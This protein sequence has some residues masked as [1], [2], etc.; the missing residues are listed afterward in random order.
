MT[1]DASTP[2][3]QAVTPTCNHEFLGIIRLSTHVRDWVTLTNS[4]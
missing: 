1:D 4:R 2:R 3:D